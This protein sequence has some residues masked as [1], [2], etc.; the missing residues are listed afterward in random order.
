MDHSLQ[1]HGSPGGFLT[2]YSFKPV[3]THRDPLTRQ[4]EESVRI[5]W[6]VERGVYYNS[7]G[8]E[9][10]VKCLNRKGEAFAP[11]QRWQE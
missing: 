4:I 9:I 11:I 2:D 5:A 6:A 8:K 7:Q 1:K 3:S 10:N